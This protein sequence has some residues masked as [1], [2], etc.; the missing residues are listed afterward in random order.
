MPD[1]R[2]KP[3]WWPKNPYPKSVFVMTIDEYAKTVPNPKTRT[4]ISG[5]LGRMFFETISDDLFERLLRAIDLE[6][7]L[8]EG[9]GWPKCAWIH[10]S[11]KVGFD[12]WDT[13]CGRRFELS[14]GR[15][16]FKYC[17]YCGKEIEEA[18]CQK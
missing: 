11:D 16:E 7:P 4:A 15:L 5:C 1:N 17:P 6:E 9:E 12:W 13:K 3:D 18:K 2:K 8:F 14:T 10:D